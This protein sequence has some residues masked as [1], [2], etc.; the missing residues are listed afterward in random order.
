[1]AATVDRWAAA[2]S[3]G[4]AGPAQAEPADR[5]VLD[6][7]GDLPVALRRLVATAGAP[8]QVCQGERRIPAGV[9]RPLVGQPLQTF[10]HP[11]K[12]VLVVGREL[13]LR[14]E[15]RD[16][17]R[18]RRPHLLQGFVEQH[19]P[20]PVGLR[21]GRRHGV[22]SRDRRLE[23]EPAVAPRR[24]RG[25]LQSRRAAAPGPTGSGRPRPGSSRRRQR[26]DRA[27]APARVVRRPAARGPRSR[28][29]TAPRA[30]LR[31]TGP[32]APCRK[33]HREA[34]ARSGARR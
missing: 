27:G 1:M 18:R 16:V 2:E 6:L 14:G 11:T 22:Q 8:A 29:G 30:R 32:V 25:V 4:L 23:R 20:R 12:L 5:V 33:G 19:D 10:L 26:R 28:R 17:H 31:S 13:G 7:A 3:S 9:R 15:Q 21:E 34:R 24:D